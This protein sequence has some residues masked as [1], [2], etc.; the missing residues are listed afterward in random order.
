M[1]S[2]NRISHLL[3]FCTDWNVVPSCQKLAVEQKELVVV[4]GQVEELKKRSDEAEE[5]LMRTQEEGGVQVGDRELVDGTSWLSCKVTRVLFWFVEA[6]G[7]LYIIFIC[8]LCRG[9]TRGSPKKPG[10]S[11]LKPA[12][13]QNAN[14]PQA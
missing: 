5:K 9:Q 2:S 14:T 4:Q 6:F 11:C 1:L 8:G 10:E 3:I 13:T 12:K 7:H